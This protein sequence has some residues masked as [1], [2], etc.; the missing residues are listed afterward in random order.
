MVFLDANVGYAVGAKG[1]LGKTIDGGTTWNIV[2]SLGYDFGLSAYGPDCYTILFKNSLEGWVGAASGSGTSYHTYDGGLT[3]TKEPAVVTPFG[4]SPN[5]YDLAYGEAS[6]HLVASGTNAFRGKYKSNAPAVIPEYAN[7]LMIPV[8]V[9][10]TL[11]FMAIANDVDK[12]DVLDMAMTGKGSLV[13]TPGVSPDTGTYSWTPVKVDSVPA[14]NVVNFQVTDCWSNSG[15]VNQTINVFMH[16]DANHDQKIT[17]SDVVFLVNYLFKG[18]PAPWLRMAA[19]ANGDTP[20]AGCNL[21]T[22]T[23]A[24]VVYLVNY[25][26]KGGPEPII[27]ADCLPVLL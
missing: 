20:D 7:T 18:G 25:L 17:V 1:L 5:F 2:D 10:Y 13:Y 21:P 12:Q 8:N 15:E 27:N 26:F 22:V 11:T 9:G 24:D 23:V 16:G 3:W 6:C 14:S 19:D 4:D